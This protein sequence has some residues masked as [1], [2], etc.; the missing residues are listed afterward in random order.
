MIWKLL[1]F[2]QCHHNTLNHCHYNKKQL[3]GYLLVS[4]SSVTALTIHRQLERNTSLQ[5][6]AIVSVCMSLAALLTIAVCAIL[7]GYKLSKR[8]MWWKHKLY[9]IL[10]SIS[11][12]VYY[13]MYIILVDSKASPWTCPHWRI[14]ICS[15][16]LI[17]VNGIIV[18]HGLKLLI[19]WV[20]NVSLC[21]IK[22]A[23]I[24]DTEGIRVDIFCAS[25]VV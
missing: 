2:L 18:F 21:R 4:C 16:T 15:M 10:L 23:D 12:S 7:S 1:M 19:E 20:S 6:A 11:G 17:P 13:I 5:K 25:Y 3:A 14:S 9:C 8:I 24:L 22:M